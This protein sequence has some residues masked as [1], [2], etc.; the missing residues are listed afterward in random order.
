MDVILKEKLMKGKLTNLTLSKSALL[1][2]LKKQ[3]DISEVERTTIL[4]VQFPEVVRQYEYEQQELKALKKD[5]RSCR[6]QYRDDRLP[7]QINIR[8]SEELERWLKSKPDYSELVR[9]LIKRQKSLDSQ[10]G[11]E[12]G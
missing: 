4:S 2:W 3:P 12:N 6:I 5:A 10:G 8:I 11:K 7:S 1:E 9:D